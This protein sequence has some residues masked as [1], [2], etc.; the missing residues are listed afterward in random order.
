MIPQIIHYC[1]FGNKS[2]PDEYLNYIET[3]RKFCP[4]FEIKKWDESNFDV[5]SNMYCKE[6]Y[7]AGKWAFV[8]DYARLKIIYEYGG[9]YLDTDVEMI[10]DIRQ[11]LKDGNGFIGF[12]NDIEVATGLGFAAE[13][14]NKCVK[15]MLDVYEGR[16]FL[17]ENGKFDLLPCPAANTYGMIKCGLNISEVRD[18]NVIMIE[19]I[20][21]YTEKYFNPY[22]VEKGKMNVTDCTYTIHH[23][24]ASWNDVKTLYIRK[25]KK[26]I[27]KYFLKR[28]TNKIAIENIN[29]IRRCVE[30]RTGHVAKL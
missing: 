22:D 26:I 4:D 8:S 12:Q 5:H 1:W 16:H 18:S 27:P 21:V 28:R 17:L 7:D 13:K 15:S 3:W 14:R 25:I 20:K 29:K 30:S 19:N 9:V 24:G 6:A 11:L 2:I 23:Y 10:K